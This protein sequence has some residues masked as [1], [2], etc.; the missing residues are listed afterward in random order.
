VTS[1]REK[2]AAARNARPRLSREEVQVS[3]AVQQFT[4]DIPAIIQ[5]AIDRFNAGEYSTPALDPQFTQTTPINS[6][7]Y[8]QRSAAQAVQALGDLP[9]V[10]ELK[11]YL[12]DPAVDMAF[13]M[14]YSADHTK[15]VYRETLRLVLLPEEP[16]AKSRIGYD[17]PSGSAELQMTD[18]DKNAWMARH[19]PKPK[20][21]APKA[22]VPK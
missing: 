4:R 20:L 22:D 10:A 16:F 18:A 1:L 3:L 6:S 17:L 21:S 14:R 9:A 12:S 11:A 15:G 13:T 2:Y 5:R 7:W 19:A 8:S